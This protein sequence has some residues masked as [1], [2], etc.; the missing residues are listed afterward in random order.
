MEKALLIWNVHINQ[1]M[2]ICMFIK[3][4]NNKKKYIL[5]FSSFGLVDNTPGSSPNFRQAG[6][7]V[8]YLF[9]KFHFNGE[10]YIGNSN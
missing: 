1:N 10:V 2:L 8:E 5:N 7:H 6:T 3:S 4:V 9:V